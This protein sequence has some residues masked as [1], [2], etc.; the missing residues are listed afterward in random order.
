MEIQCNICKVKRDVGS[1]VDVVCLP[2]HDAVKAQRDDLLAAC[3]A[4]VRLWP[5][6]DGKI[7]ATPDVQRCYKT[8][9]AAIAAATK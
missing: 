8:A 9:K 3:E 2:C 1:S 6:V 7:K 4:F 5:V